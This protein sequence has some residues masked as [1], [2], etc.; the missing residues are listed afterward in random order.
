V[1]Q[2]NLFIFALFTSASTA[3]SNASLQTAATQQED[4]DSNNCPINTP[5]GWSTTAERYNPLTRAW[6]SAGTMAEARYAHAAVAL[7]S[8]KV[9]V[10]GGKG[11]APGGLASAELYTP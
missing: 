8:G 10:V 9:L 1:K 6:T 7:H 11:L 4:E 5:Q 3:C 2:I